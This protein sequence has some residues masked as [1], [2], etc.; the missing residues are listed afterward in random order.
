VP[1]LVFVAGVLALPCLALGTLAPPARAR[2]GQTPAKVVLA[3][4]AGAPPVVRAVALS[5]SL[6]TVLHRGLAVRYSVG[7]EVAGHFEV[8]MA[9]SFAHRIGLR[10]SPPRGLPRRAAP[11][12]VIG[13]A[14]LVTIAGG[15]STLK[16]HFGRAS[17]VRLRR[18]ARLR[19]L[20][21]V[22]LTLRLVVRNAKTPVTTTL[23]SR[24]ILSA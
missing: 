21:K 10:G 5:R 11:Q 7:E 9:R 13:R 15:R 2:A 17:V 14:L 6:R 4:D 3:V 1:T 19:R 16:L 8:L 18:A 22:P 24:F 20:H 12:I 23:L